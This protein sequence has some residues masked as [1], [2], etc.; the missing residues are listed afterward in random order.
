MQ[1]LAGDVHLG[2]FDGLN[3]SKTLEQVFYSMHS[4]R[5]G[6]QSVVSKRRLP[7]LHQATTDEV[8][9]HGRWRVK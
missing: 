7:P 4:Y 1:H 5:R 6:A 3:G 8:N 9:E 2:P